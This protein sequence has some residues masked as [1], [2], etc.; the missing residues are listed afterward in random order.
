M[1]EGKYKID[2]KLPSENEMADLYGVPR[3]SVR[4]AYVK[5]EEMGYLYTKQG[6]GRYVNDRQQ[7][8]ELVLSGNESFSKKM[9]D[10]GYHLVSSNV[11][12][13]KI[14]YDRRIYQE[15]HVE[16]CDAV[17]KIGRLRIINSVPMA[18]HIS[19]VAKS[20]FPNIEQESKDIESM[21]Q[22]YKQNG[23]KAF[24][25]E[26]SILSISFPILK[27]RELLQCSNLIPLLTVETNCVDA[28]SKKVLEYT[29]IVYRSDCFKYIVP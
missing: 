3:I 6:K 7:A 21:F 23:Y 2:D 1:N 11:L 15:L 28:V 20:V 8:I 24:D 14:N 17:Y 12:C 25:S 16:K 19:Y 9:L 4:K 22:Y 27:E 13:E 29:N 10:K 26:K 5:L 18:L